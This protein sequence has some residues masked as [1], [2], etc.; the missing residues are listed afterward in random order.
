MTSGARALA[1]VQE[2]DES[3]TTLL[4]GSYI[5]PEQ[6]IQGQ[7]IMGQIEYQSIA[8]KLLQ[9]AEADQDMRRWAA[10]QPDWLARY[11][12]CRG[13]GV[14]G[15]MADRPAYARSGVHG[16]LPGVDA[17]ASR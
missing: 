5:A 1:P 15:G 17:G 9:M 7:R 4:D 2:Y 6:A 3:R 8:A 12:T 14:A 13:R 10:H 16:A 11:P